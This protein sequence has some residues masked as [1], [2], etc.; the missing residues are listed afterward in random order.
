MQFG[1]AVL[2]L[3]QRF[4]EQ[5]MDIVDEVRGQVQRLVVVD[6]DLLYLVDG[7]VREVA[8]AILSSVTQ[9][10]AVAVSDLFVASV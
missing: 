3:G 4:I 5:L 2:F 1:H 10:I 8:Y 7:Q 6:D 9:E